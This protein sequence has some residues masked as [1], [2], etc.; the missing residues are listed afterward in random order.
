MTENDG[1]KNAPNSGTGG[2]PP[3][4]AAPQGPPPPQQPPVLPKAPGTPPSAG[5]GT[6]PPGFPPPAPPGPGAVPPGTPPRGQIRNQVAGVTQP[7]PP[8]LAEQRAR[9]HALREQEEQRLAYEAEQA[10][11]QKLRKRLL[12]GGGVGVGVVALVAIWYAA[13]T[14]DEVEAQCTADGVVVDDKYCSESYATSNGGHV[15][16]GF[17]YIGGS[18]YRYHYGGASTPVGQKVSGGSYTMPDNSKVTTKSGSTVQRGGFGV[19]DGGKSSGGTKS[20]GS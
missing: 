12:I 19:V 1:T 5:P 16:G 13:S 20:G 4:P 9:E 7:R 15:S 8:S 10:R 6:P 14:P 17:I 11:K 18:S 2:N 3:P